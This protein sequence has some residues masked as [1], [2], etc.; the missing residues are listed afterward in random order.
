MEVILYLSIR[1]YT[2]FYCFRD[3]YYRVEVTFCDKNIP[4]DPGFT[5]DLS[6]RMNYD[7]MANAVAQYLVT[8]PYLLQFFK[9]QR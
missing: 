6:L 2:N 1:T 3:L 5:L 8:D 9:P 4:N 7:A